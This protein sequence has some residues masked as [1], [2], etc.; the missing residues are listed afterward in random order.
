[1]HPEIV[2]LRPKL[3]EILYDCAVDIKATKAALYLLDN[4]TR[5]YDLVTEFGFRS[6]IRQTAGTNDPMVDRCSRGKAPFYVNTPGADPKLS[7]LF[8]RSSSE[9]LLAVPIF[10]RGQLIGF[11]DIRDKTQKQPFDP[12]DISKAQRIADRMLGLLTNKNLW[13]RRFTTLADV[14]FIGTSATEKER[15]RFPGDSRHIKLAPAGATAAAPASA[16]ALAGVRQQKSGT[17]SKVIA[18][19][20]AAA[21]RLLSAAQS[22]TLGPAELNAVRDALRSMLLLPGAVAVVYTGHDVQ[23]VASRGTMTQ[24]AM[25]SLNMKLQ[26]WLNKR[27]ETIGAVRPSMTTPPGVDASPVTV[28]DLQKIFTAAVNARTGGYLTIAFQQPPEKATHELLSAQ[29]AHLEAAIEGTASRSA[30]STMRLSVAEWLVEP[31]FSSYP[32]LKHHSYATAALTEEFSKFLGLAQSDAE[33][34]K[35]IALVHDCGMRL[36]DYDR[37]YSKPNLNHD[38]LKFLREHPV[39]GAA[40]VETLLGPEVAKAVLCHHERVDGAGYPNELRGDDIPLG[41]RVVQICEVYVAIVDPS[42]YQRPER[43]EDALTAIRRGAGAQFD[44]ELAV[45]FDEMMRARAAA[46]AN[47]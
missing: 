34:L 14:D 11:I 27:G 4:G 43:P 5:K 33:T 18:D 41:S 19:A 20:Y 26:G 3:K 24:D 16:P 9:R 15:E 10:S 38:E 32:A 25:S 46:P 47:R 22:E 13:N 1:M 42:T 36:L 31:A 6:A 44:K 29:L 28:S 37:L 21:A 45:R 8:F 35:V 2:E 12:M 40:M 23:E 17:P 39:V 30:L 7:E